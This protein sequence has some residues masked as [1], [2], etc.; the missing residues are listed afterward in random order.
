MEGPLAAALEVLRGRSERSAPWVRELR[1]RESAGS[2]TQPVEQLADSYMHMHVNRMLRTAA[3][4]QEFVLY[5][6]LHRLYESRAARQR[7]AVLSAGR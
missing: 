1:A 2:L 5:D 7:R 3:R 4:A 6:L